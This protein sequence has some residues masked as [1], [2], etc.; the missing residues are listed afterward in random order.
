M[1]ILLMAIMTRCAGRDVGRTETMPAKR[2][3][4][5]SRLNY[6]AGKKFFIPKI[7]PLLRKHLH[8]SSLRNKGGG[9]KRDRTADLLT[10][11]QALSQL[12][13]TPKLL[14]LL[15]AKIYYH[16]QSKIASPFFKKMYFLKGCTKIGNLFGKTYL[17]MSGKFR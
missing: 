2:Q 12:S 16:I 8:E 15:T 14:R 3:K 6:G 4:S 11:S 17:K 7:K 10:A 1:Y 5:I 13:Y 9:D